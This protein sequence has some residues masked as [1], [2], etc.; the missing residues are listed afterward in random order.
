MWARL[1]RTL[2]EPWS[3]ICAEKMGGRGVTGRGT[4]A[5]PT[6]RREPSQQLYMPPPERQR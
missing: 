4:P 6:T 2:R 3:R 5:A 1:G